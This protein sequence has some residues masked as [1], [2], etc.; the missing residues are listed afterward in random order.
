MINIISKIPAIRILFPYIFGIL[1]AS[2]WEI[3]SIYAII[4]A[5]VSGITY[6]IL[7]YINKPEI[8]LTKSYLFHLPIFLI[9]LCLGC[10]CYN[11]NYPKQLPVINYNNSIIAKA[12]IQRINDKDFSVNMNIKVVQMTDSCKKTYNLNH[13][14]T[15]WL[16]GNNYSLKEGDIILFK[17]RPHRIQNNGNPEEFDYQNHMINKGYLYHTFIN[18]NDYTIIGHQNNLFIFFRNIQ[19]TLINKLLESQLKPDTKI[20]LITIILG[21]SYY[22]NSD[23]RDNMA[24]AGIAHI[25]ALSGL[26]MGIIAFIISTLLSPLDCFKMKRIR[27]FLTLIVSILFVFL[28]GLSL[29]AVRAVIMIGFIII[30]K[31]TRNK[32]S[33]INALL[34]A[35][36]L[37]LIATPSAIYDIGFQFSFISI[38]VIIISASQTQIILPKNKLSRYFISIIIST[39]IIAIGTTVLTAFYFNYISLS[40]MFTN[41]IILPILPII[42]GC[43]FIYLLLSFLGINCNIMTEIVNSFYEFIVYVTTDINNC[44][45]SYIDNIYISETSLCLYFIALIF[46][47]IFIYKHKVIYIYCSLCFIIGLV[48]V[49]LIEISKLPNSGYILFND[50]FYMPILKFKGDTA[51][52]IIPNDTLE[53]DKFKRRHRMFLA[54]HKINHIKID[55]NSNVQHIILGNKRIAIIKDSM[56]KRQITSSKIDTDIILITKGFYGDIKYILQN[57]NTKL[58]VLSGNIYYKQQEEFNNECKKNGIKCYNMATQGSLFEYFI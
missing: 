34:F 37:I 48:A 38:T 11:L 47:I 56:I 42:I 2:S 50:N 13:K 17:F 44:R 26:H 4:I 19:R 58:I 9:F 52:I 43:G 25:L 57:Y 5:V 33:S 22:L 32:Y 18:E 55:N 10:I 6:I 39:L 20:F 49:H 16:E 51:Q 29:S 31:I 23:L 28:T 8:R 15:A 41:L 40:S 27:L 7:S 53:I 45:I 30:S 24:F 3:S 35:A 46:I 14:M 54:K 36:L 12:I 21:D 1:F